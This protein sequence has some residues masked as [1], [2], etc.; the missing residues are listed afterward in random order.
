MLCQLYHCNPAHP[1]R[2]AW[3]HLAFSAALKAAAL[4]ALG[5][6]TRRAG[7]RPTSPA[8][9]STAAAPPLASFRLFRCPGDSGPLPHPQSGDAERWN[10]DASGAA[11]GGRVSNSGSSGDES[12]V[13]AGGD[14]SAA[15]ACWMTDASAMGEGGSGSSQEMTPVHM[16]R[17]CCQIPDLMYIA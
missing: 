15:K 1:I 5:T 14:D 8:S 6:T 17:R 11:S 16:I 9:P 10:S 3:T 2:H 4:P 12:A 13:A 7:I